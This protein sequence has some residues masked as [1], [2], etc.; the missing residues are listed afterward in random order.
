MYGKYLG[1]MAKFAFLASAVHQLVFT[2]GSNLPFAVG[3]VQDVGAPPLPPTTPPAWGCGLH[4]RC[5]V[6]RVTLD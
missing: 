1:Q 2:L 4:R 6:R 3:Q 5:H